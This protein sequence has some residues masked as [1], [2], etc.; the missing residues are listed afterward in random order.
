MFLGLGHLIQISIQHTQAELQEEKLINSQLKRMITFVQEMVDQTNL[1]ING[2]QKQLQQMLNVHEADITK[3]QLA[4]IELMKQI[5]TM[6]KSGQRE[7]RQSRTELC[8]GKNKI[9]WIKIDRTSIYHHQQA[10]CERQPKFMRLRDK[11]VIMGVPHKWKGC[12][13]I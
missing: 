10:G 12:I 11:P 4:E 6:L 7:I 1:T 9:K 5:R 3:M 2:K 13:K 8:V